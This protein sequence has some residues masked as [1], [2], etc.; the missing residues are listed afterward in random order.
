M[1]ATLTE[2]PALNGAYYFKELPNAPAVLPS[3]TGTA[4]SPINNGE[5]ETLDSTVLQS[6]PNNPF[7]IKSTGDAS[8]GTGQIVGIC[9]NTK[10]ISQGQFGQF[11]VFVFTTDGIYTMSVN[12]D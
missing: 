4:P 2:H 10:A 9:S 5:T 6:E 3:A 8:V 1:D 7:V 11:P 12:S